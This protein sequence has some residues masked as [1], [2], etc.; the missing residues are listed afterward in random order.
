MRLHTFSRRLL[1]AL[2]PLALA[3]AASAQITIDECG[4]LINQ[5]FGGCNLLFQADSGIVLQD[6]TGSA[7][8]GHVLGDQIHITGTYNNLCA[9]FCTIN[10]CL[11]SSFA[12]TSCTPP[13][14]GTAYC[15]GDGS[16]TACPCGNAGGATEG[17]ANSSGAGATLAGTGTASVGADDLGFDAAQLL[18]NQP[19]LL[20]S[21]DAQVAGGAGAIFGDG[22][23]CAGQNVRRLGVRVPNAAG[24]SS[25]SGGL[26]ATGGW[27]AGDTR[28]F[29]VWYRDP[30]ASPCGTAF[31]LSH[32][33]AV[34]FAP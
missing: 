13:P 31:N 23:R 15:F 12:V 22:L 11:V 16:G 34:T 6:N 9:T 20:F 4:T 26:G 24:T 19:A 30:I 32:G 27:S 5:P 18:P 29:Q 21:G 14:P 25:W 1:G 33:V 8:G 17:C 28:N 10:G 3:A 2:A 7:F